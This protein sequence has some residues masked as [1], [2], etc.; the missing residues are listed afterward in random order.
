M[1]LS[2]AELLPVTSRAEGDLGRFTVLSRLSSSFYATPPRK[3]V[4]L[5]RAH[6]ERMRMVGVHGRVFSSVLVA[7]KCQGARSKQFN[8]KFRGVTPFK[9][10]IQS[11]LCPWNLPVV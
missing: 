10:A 4:S 1:T 6:L 5:K 3:R 8:C 2:H 11:I 7:M 9:R